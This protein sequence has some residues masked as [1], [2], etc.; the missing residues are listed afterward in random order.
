M[1]KPV[2]LDVMLDDKYIC[3]LKCIRR[4]FPK[5]VNGEVIENYEDDE[6]FRAFVEKQRPSLKGKPFKVIPSNQKI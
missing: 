3:Q 2:L 4:G 6:Y 5:I 1:K